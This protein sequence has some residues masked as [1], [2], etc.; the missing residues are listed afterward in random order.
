MEERG[1][2]HVYRIPARADGTYRYMLAA[3]WSE[4]TVLKTPQ[5]FADYV[6]ASARS[7]NSPPRLDGAREERKP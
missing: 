7:Y 6:A 4:G 5:E 2:N 3:G 1:G